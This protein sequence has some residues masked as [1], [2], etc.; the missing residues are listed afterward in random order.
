MHA[1][2]WRGGRTHLSRPTHIFRSFTIMALTSTLHRRETKKFSRKKK[3]RK[4]IEKKN[5]FCRKN[6]QKN[7]NSRSLK[8]CMVCTHMQQQNREVEED[9][10]EEKNNFTF[11]SS[12][13]FPHFPPLFSKTNPPLRAIKIFIITPQPTPTFGHPPGNLIFSFLFTIC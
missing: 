8:L 1:H 7:I 6:S 12:I 10:D 9:E 13:F 2:V 11:S 3:L 4:K 5:I